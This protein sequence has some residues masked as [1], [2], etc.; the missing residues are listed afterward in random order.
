MAF[1]TH[2]PYFL[3]DQHARV[4]RTVRLVTNA[5]ALE[6][7]YGVLKRKRTT[8]VAVAFQAPRFVR[9]ERLCHRPPD[10]AMGIV[11]I[12]AGHRAFGQLMVIRALKLCPDIQV[13]GRALIVDGGSLAGHQAMRPTSMNFMTGSAGNLILH[14]AALE[15]ANVRRLI[16]VTVKTNAIG[17]C[18]R[19]LR[20]V[21][22]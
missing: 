14:V 9:A 21:A 15:A 3:P 5:A 8:L 16:Q 4:S 6:P 17:R 11:T 13:A 1:E 7:D 19:K 20:R 10:A 2:K 12:D 22:D 18:W